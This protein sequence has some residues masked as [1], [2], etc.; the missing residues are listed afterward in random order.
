MEHACDSYIADLRIFNGSITL[1]F[2]VL[3]I[4]LEKT[5]DSTHKNIIKLCC[6]KMSGPVTNTFHDI[7]PFACIASESDLMLNPY[8]I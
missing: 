4:Q 3:V 5:A 8:S 7:N 2:E 6:V 1:Y